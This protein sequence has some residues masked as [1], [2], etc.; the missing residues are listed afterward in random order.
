MLQASSAFADSRKHF[1]VLDALRGVA[2]IMVVLFHVLEVYSGGDHVK[3]VINHGYLAVD[4]F[5][6]LSGFVMAHAYDGRWSTMTLTDFFK[7]R[8]IRLHPMI[9]LGM[10][11]GAL[12]F[13]P[14]ASD[15]FPKIETTPLWQL[16]LVLLVGYTLI[17]LPPSM[18]IR[19]WNEMHPLNGP[20]WSLFLEYIANIL[21]ALILRRLSKIALGV[22]VMGSAIALIHMAVTRGDIIGGWSLEPTQLWIGFTRLMFPYTAGMLLRRLMLIEA[23]R[24]T[25]LLCSAL[26]IVVMA[27]PRLGGYNNAWMNGAYEALI[28]ILV[29]PAIIMLGAVGEVK[30]QHAQKLCKFLGDISY[31]IYILHFP[32][33]YVF[34]KWVVEN[35]VPLVT[36]FIT[37]LGLVAL[38]LLFSYTALKL[39]DEPV[40]RKLAHRFLRTARAAST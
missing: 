12:L 23:K 36:G 6:M 13:Y 39:Y 1:M 24:N 32:F 40:R 27:V 8:I 37:G 20:A 28:I 26:L 3:Q 7:R 17:P 2:A 34:Y 11:V 9:M 38:V 18:D 16:L 31:P 22:V 21:H 5:F 25:F 30:Q 19:G 14:A 33:A 35:E 4:F 29:F 15:Y 10:T